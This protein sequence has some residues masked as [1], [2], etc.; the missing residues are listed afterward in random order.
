[1]SIEFIAKHTGLTKAEI[2][3]LVKENKGT[4]LPPQI[5]HHLERHKTGERQRTHTLAKL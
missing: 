1:M 3:A 5:Y 2:N 4:D